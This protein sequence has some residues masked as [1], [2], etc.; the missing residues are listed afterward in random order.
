MIA[1]QDRPAQFN[2]NKLLWKAHIEQSKTKFKDIKFFS[3]KIYFDSVDPLKVRFIFYY[4]FLYF[5]ILG[6]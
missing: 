1:L 3:P 2:Y 5:F 6:I 4:F